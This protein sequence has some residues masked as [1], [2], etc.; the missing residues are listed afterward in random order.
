MVQVRFLC[1]FFYGALYF[2]VGI[3]L[4]ANFKVINKHMR[5]SRLTDTK[6]DITAKFHRFKLSQ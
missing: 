2:A 4:K 3:E 1:F 6:K 5:I